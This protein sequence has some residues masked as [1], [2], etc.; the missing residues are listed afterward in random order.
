MSV[1]LDPSSTLAFSR[2]LTRPVKC[3]LTITNSS[4]A[5][6]VAFKVKTN[7]VKSYA[8]RPN[9]GT[10][11]PGQTVEI[12]ELYNSSRKEH[13]PLKEIWSTVASEELHS[14]K[15]RVVYLPAHV[16]LLV[17]MKST[18]ARMRQRLCSKLSSLFLHMAS[19]A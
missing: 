16:S 14:H 8:V 15:L 5:Q 10:L 6:S 19:E 12:E 17:A 13:T 2:P 7:A 9:Y 11:Q 4:N 3:A 1:T 18:L